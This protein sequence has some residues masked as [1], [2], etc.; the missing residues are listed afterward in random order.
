[1][2]GSD[3]LLRRVRNPRAESEAGLRHSLDAEVMAWMMVYCEAYTHATSCGGAR[4]SALSGMRRIRPP[5]WGQRGTSSGC[6]GSLGAG[7]DGRKARARSSGPPGWA[8][9]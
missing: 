9:A 7:A 3:L 2:E 8:Q 1:M 6:A 5:H 4:A